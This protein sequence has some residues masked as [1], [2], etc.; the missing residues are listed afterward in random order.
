MFGEIDL[1]K[2]PIKPQ[3]FLAK[4]DKEIIAK[5][6]EAYPPQQ[7][8]KLNALNDIRVQLPYEVEVH[9]QLVPNEH[10]PLIK[11]RY[12]LKVVLGDS[13]E[14]Y[15]ITS[16]SDEMEDNGDRRTV[17]A[18][19]LAYE[20]SDKML[21]DYK[22]VSYHAGQIMNDLLSRTVWSVGY[23]DADF[24]LAY[25]D[26]EFSSN[27][28]LD[29]VYQV[30]ETYNAIVKWDTINRKVSLMKPELYGLNKGLKFSYGHYLKRMGRESKA[31]EMVTRLKGYGKEGLSIER[32]NPTGQPYIQDLSYFLYPFERDAAKKVLQHSDYMTDSLCHALLDYDGLV[33][34]NKGTF[35]SLL[36]RKEPLQASLSARQNELNALKL[37]QSQITSLKNN[38]QFDKNMWFEKFTYSGP[39]R[40]VVTTLKSSVN[41][42]AVFC[43]VSDVSNLS[44]TVN[45]TPSRLAANEWVLSGKISGSLQSV[46]QLSGS[47][48]DTEIFIQTASITKDEFTGTGN[49]DALINK[50]S[51]D[52][53]EM[54]IEAKT[55]EIKNLQD[56]MDQ[57]E[58]QITALKKLLSA[59]ENF[60]RDQLNELNPFIIEKEFVDENYIHDKD[61]YKDLMEKF[62]EMQKPQL[63]F[64]IDI[65]NF[66]EIVEEQHNWDKLVLGDTVTIEYEKMRTKV[67]AR[68]IEMAFDYGSGSVGLT[69]ANV[70]DISDP[71]KKMEKFMATSIG[72]SATL[73]HNK[74]RW[75]KAV[76]DASETSQ[77]ME[78][79]WNKVT[80]EINMANNEYVTLDR[81]GLTITDPA[82]PNRFLRA[83]HGS[84]ALTRSGG[85][86]YETA[87][88]PDGIIAERLMGKILTTNRVIIGDDDGIWLTEG[89]K[90]TITD[91]CDREV[92]KIGLIEEKPDRFGLTINRF[93]TQDCSLASSIVNKVTLDSENGLTLERKR[94]NGF[95]KTL[96]T[97]LD[98][99]LFM[100]G[101]FQAG[102]GNQVFKVDKDGVAIGSSVWANAPSRFDY[103][104]NFYT[105]AM[106]AVT[107][108][109]EQSQFKDGHIVGSDLTIGTGDLAFRVFPNIGI[110]A[111]HQS[112]GSAPFSVSLDG[113]LKARKA[114]I[115]NGKN[116]VLVDSEKGKMFLHNFDIEGAG[117]IAAELLA[118]TTITAEDGYISNLTVSR[119][120]TLGKDADVGQFVNYME[121]QDKQF[122][123]I[124][125]KVEAKEQSKD[126]KGNLL[127]WTDDKRQILTKE[128]TSYIAYQFKLGDIHEKMITDFLNEGEHA[129]PRRVMGDGDGGTNPL[130]VNNIDY[131]TGRA[132][133]LKY[134]GGLDYRYV[135]NN[136]PHDRSLQFTDKG[137]QLNS[138]LAPIETLSKDYVIKL[139]DEKTGQF[140]VQ[141][142]N[143]SSKFVFGPNGEVTLVGGNMT[144]TGKN[145]SF[146]ADDFRV[147]SKEVNF[148]K[149]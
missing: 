103:Y 129:L 20:L 87:I 50:Y 123:W 98:G 28:V 26:F 137:V 86:R 89:A 92:M 108:E 128:K 70:K 44:V 88:T 115:T 77:L 142:E 48:K 106:H 114:L 95:E 24:E 72:T 97:S 59:E 29:A 51:L 30:A 6:S 15:I 109:I 76:I 130:T 110:W 117:R 78:N 121:I 21:K 66:L 17:T 136:L 82:D 33:E 56:Q 134:N 113:T 60:T 62:R 145:I 32:V 16:P 53:K 73:N 149:K 35:E 146:E 64:N 5:L 4:P 11:E 58:V 8:I 148:V 127:Y 116:E 120:K 132:Y 94:T 133:E 42:Y 61:L 49:D 139:E 125:A 9:H 25:R 96:Y 47:P 23:I 43:K 126:S 111:G 65:V 7:N 147:T 143:S 18:Y 75:G 41:R 105:R 131:N 80:Q 1:L 144:F 118:V 52:H 90:T 37:E 101:N 102:E 81:S 83:T 2:K 140:S 10:I 93:D 74:D 79:F 122:K 119:L 135:T 55:A 67:T 100:K 84:L 91:R 107:A 45:G 138:Q 112:F 12:L 34:A 63:L 14:W 69:I 39:S 99:D 19:S 13:E 22:Q 40:S 36:N 27:T 68:I 57:I 71:Y 104:G 141:F 46:V 54:Q 31:D 3:I 124:T 38:Q 85:L